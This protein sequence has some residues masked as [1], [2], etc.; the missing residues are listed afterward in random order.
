MRNLY[1]VDAAPPVVKRFDFTTIDS[2]F[3]DIPCG[4]VWPLLLHVTPVP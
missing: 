3:L 1:N 4:F 2:A